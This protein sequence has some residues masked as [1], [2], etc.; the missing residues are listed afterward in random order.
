M[1]RRLIQ[2]LRLLPSRSGPSEECRSRVGGGRRP[3]GPLRQP[4]RAVGPPRRRLGRPRPQRHLDPARNPFVSTIPYGLCPADWSAGLFHDSDDGQGSLNVPLTWPTFTI[5]VTHATRNTIAFDTHSAPDQLVPG[6]RGAFWSACFSGWLL[7]SQPGS[8]RF[9]FD[10][11]DDSGR[12]FL[13]DEK[14]FESRIVHGPRDGTVEQFLPAGLIPVTAEYAQG[15]ADEAGLFLNWAGPG[16]AK[17]LLDPIRLLGA[18]I[19]LTPHAGRVGSNRAL[20]P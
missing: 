2:L 1:D 3:L 19:A 20:W 8:L 13:N 11:L 6:L 10:R 12:L 4:P 16:W 7:V 9:F 5:L 17:E 15:P 14:V 18:G